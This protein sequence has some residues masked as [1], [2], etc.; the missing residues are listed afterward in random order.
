[1]FDLGFNITDKGASISGHSSEKDSC[2]AKEGA[3]S[4]VESYKSPK[5]LRNKMEHNPPR[6][7]QPL[8]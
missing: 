1:M 7:V 2:F 6:E 3:E 5:V 8:C 4:T